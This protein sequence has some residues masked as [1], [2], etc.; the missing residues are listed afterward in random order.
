MVSG[1]PETAADRFRSY[2]ALA[3]NM[4][5]SAVAQVCLLFDAPFLE[6]RGISNIAGVRDKD[7]W[8]F[9]KAITH[10]HAVTRHLLESFSRGVCQAP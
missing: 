3:E 4:E 10:C 2:G 6:W 7:R 8:D 9:P 5:G 1:D